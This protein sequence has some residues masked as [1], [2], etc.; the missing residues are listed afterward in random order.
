MYATFEIRQKNLTKARKTLVNNFF[1]S[2]FF[3]GFTR[4]YEMFWEFFQGLAIGKYPKNKLFKGYIDLEIQLQEVDR[5]R[6]LYEKY[7][8]FN[9]ENCLAWVQV[10]A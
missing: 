1:S 5:C 4:I 8:S 6:K 2:S 9:P 7:L 10:S 3:S